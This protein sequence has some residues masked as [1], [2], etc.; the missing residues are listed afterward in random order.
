[1]S[2]DQAVQPIGRLAALL[3]ERFGAPRQEFVADQVALMLRNK[4]GI[5]FDGGFMPVYPKQKRV[6]T[7]EG[8]QQ[9]SVSYRSDALVPPHY[10]VASHYIVRGGVLCREAGMG[11]SYVHGLHYGS[12]RANPV[13]GNA[14]AYVAQEFIKAMGIKIGEVNFPELGDIA[15]IPKGTPLHTLMYS[16]DMAS[17]ICLRE[18]IEAAIGSYPGTIIPVSA[19]RS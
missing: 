2:E 1:M 14:K 15:M 7:L 12:P 13:S 8:G 5:E 9:V 19:S 10:F 4:H 6:F 11:V 3:E 17:V 16:E 18:E